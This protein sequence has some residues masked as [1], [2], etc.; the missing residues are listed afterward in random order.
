MYIDQSPPGSPSLAS[1][2]TQVQNVPG[3][4]SIHSS[5]ASSKSVEEYVG[6]KRKW[7][8]EFKTMAREEHKKYMSVLDAQESYYI[9]LREL[10]VE[11]A[12]EEQHQRDQND[13]I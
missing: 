5:V 8:E 2:P 13:S 7:L 11:K 3:P 9:T 1:T 10:A 6:Q 12:M 4:S